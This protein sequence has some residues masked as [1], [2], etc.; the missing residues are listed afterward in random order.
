MRVRVEVEEGADSRAVEKGAAGK[1]EQP[2]RGWCPQVEEVNEVEEKRRAMKGRD[3][4]RRRYMDGLRT[5]YDGDE[6]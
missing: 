2:S 6:G 4:E 3:G 5:W 1:T